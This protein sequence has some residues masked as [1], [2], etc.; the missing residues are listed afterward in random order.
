MVHKNIKQHYKSYK[1][2]VKIREQ[3]TFC[4]I[5]PRKFSSFEINRNNLKF[6]VD[7]PFTFSDSVQSITLQDSEVSAG[8]NVVVSGWGATW[9]SQYIKYCVK[10]QLTFCQNF[11]K[12]T[13]TYRKPSTM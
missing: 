1:S 4:L 10:Q 2:Q 7:P 11:S 8:T 13:T 5:V 3:N 12:L 9:V 6:Q